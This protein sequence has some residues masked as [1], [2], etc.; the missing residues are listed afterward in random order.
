MSQSLQK[1][2]RDGL[3]AVV[4]WVLEG[5]LEVVA[6]LQRQAADVVVG[7]DDRVRVRVKDDHIAK[8]VQFHP[9]K[10][11]LKIVDG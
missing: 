3:A 8:F 5:A 7:A 10:S 11:H 2:P 4:V 6:H 9:L 1:C